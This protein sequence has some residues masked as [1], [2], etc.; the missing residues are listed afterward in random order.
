MDMMNSI[1]L[2]LSEC[3]VWCAV[4]GCSWCVNSAFH[5]EAPAEPVS[6]SLYI[7]S[8]KSEESFSSSMSSMSS[9]NVLAN[10]S[11]ENSEGKCN[12]YIF[13]DS[14]SSGSSS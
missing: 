1:S 10:R 12:I 3:N 5:C 11:N 6:Y 13:A 14:P 4:Y 7:K 8:V 9:L 2:G